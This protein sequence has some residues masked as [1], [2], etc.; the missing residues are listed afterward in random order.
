MK[1]TPT[2]TLIFL[3][4]SIFVQGQNTIYSNSISGNDSTGDGTSENPFKTF[5]K[6]YTV[7]VSGDTINLTG[8]FTWTDADEV[9]DNPI[10]GYNITKDLTIEG[11]SSNTTIIQAAE[12][13][14]TATSRVF[15]A[16]ST[17]SFNELTIRNLTIKNG[18]STSDDKTSGG[19]LVKTTTSNYV[20]QLN[21]YQCSFENNRINSFTS[22]NGFSGGAL[23]FSGYAYG[24]LNIEKSTFKDNHAYIRSYGAGALYINQSVNANVVECTFEGNYGQSN[25]DNFYY[26]ASAAIYAYRNSI[27]KI[28]NCTFAS[29]SSVGTSGAILAHQNT[30]FL[31]NNTIAGNSTTNTG[32]TGG[33]AFNSPTAIY[34]KNNI[35]ANNTLN[36][37]PNDFNSS[38]SISSNGFNIVEFSANLITTSDDITGDQVNLFGTNLATTPDLNAT[39]TI[40]LS[41]GSVAIDK[42]SSDP[43][44]T[45]EI[46]AKDQRGLGRVLSVDIGSYEYVEASLSINDNLNNSVTIYP[47]P[48]SSSVYI[49]QDFSVAKVYD[50]TGRELLKSNSKTIHLTGLTSNIYLIKLF[51]SSNKL[52]ATSKI[53]KE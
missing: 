4:F 15:T 13:S 9:G 31:T 34:L 23:A 44:N 51:D 30:T 1:S 35:I 21:V 2:F 42:G 41:S 24:T 53:I 38:S 22:D 32:L 19:I 49:E 37:T 8:T 40:S 16:E 29:N 33:V 20:F 52:I 26:G 25:Y 6:S 14:N 43:N 5:H 45:V 27:V 7:A 10:V 50:L 11:Q 28:T 17:S 48:T 12:T 18:V 3:L 46:P 39:K 36:G 47:N